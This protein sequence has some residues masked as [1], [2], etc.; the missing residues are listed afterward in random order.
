MARLTE[1]RIGALRKPGTYGDGA[2]G[3]GWGLRL[4]VHRTRGGHVTKSF[5]QV[6]RI[7]NKPTSV[8]LGSWPETSLADARTR[9]LENVLA[10]RH[11]IDPRTV[12][13]VEFRVE[14]SAPVPSEPAGEPAG[15]T[16]GEAAEAWKALHGTG[17]SKGYRAAI[18]RNL[19]RLSSLLPKPVA[20][21]T[22]TDVRRALMEHWTERHTVAG[23]ML[24]AVVKVTEW[25]VAMGHRAAPVTAASVRAGLPKI[26]GTTK[27]HAAA[28]V[29]DMPAILRN[30]RALP[31]RNPDMT[32]CVEFVILTAARQKEATGATWGEI[33]KDAMTWTVPA[34]RMKAKREHV[35]PLTAP[36]LA[37]L[38][39]RG[40]AGD[41][42]FRN[43]AGNRLHQASLGNVLKRLGLE[44]TMHGFRATFRTWCSEQGVPREVAE[45]CLAHRIGDATEQAYA[46]ADLLAKRRSVI[47]AW[48]EHLAA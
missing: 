28:K 34:S 7:G 2:R 20:S 17:W 22:E 11:G 5:S 39:T 47:E 14:G 40:R 42:I 35:V 9:C 46:R 6:L 25:A 23:N 38:G 3:V 19:K 24:Q 29:E 10:V 32:R 48:A 37:A 21:L 1:S 27:H 30:L 18:D 44:V 41:L 26:N 33:D 36:A 8:G 31:T 12:A 4:R 45:L 43:A 15:P 16:F 13:G